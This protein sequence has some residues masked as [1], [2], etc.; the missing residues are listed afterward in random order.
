MG[1][2][3]SHKPTC[4]SLNPISTNVR[5]LVTH[6]GQCPG[7]SQPKCNCQPEQ[8]KECAMGMRNA[9]PFALDL[10]TRMGITQ[11]SRLAEH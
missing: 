10:T 5:C 11:S 2:F 4:A 3:I 7:F 1:A 8:P 9:T 6:I